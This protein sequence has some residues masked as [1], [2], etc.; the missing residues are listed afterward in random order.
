MPKSFPA[1]YQHRREPLTR[2]EAGRLENAARSPKERLVVWMLL[3]LGLRRNEL[4]GLRRQ[5]VDWQTGR[6]T[7][8]GKGGPYGSQS[9]RRVVRLTP[10]VRALLE[11][12]LALEDRLPLSAR[13][14]HRIVQ[15]VASRSAITRPCS[16]HVL[17]HTFAVTM[18]QRGLSL[19]ALQRLL[20]HDHLTTTAIYLNLS[21]DEAVREFEEKVIAA[22]RD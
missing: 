13:T 11:H 12:F 21:G 10:R 18:L 3:D 19:P 4:V 7:V 14:I 22:S 16:P 9:K 5:D 20:G 17:R 6:L 2:D 1:T 8:R 15:A